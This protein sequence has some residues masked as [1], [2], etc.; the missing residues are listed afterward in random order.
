MLKLIIFWPRYSGSKATDEIVKLSCKL[1]LL[2]IRYFLVDLI[3]GG[4]GLEEP[5]PGKHP[6]GT[7]MSLNDLVT[8]QAHKNGQF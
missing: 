4:G 7:F 5:P 6:S 3:W 8:H 2:D 1:T